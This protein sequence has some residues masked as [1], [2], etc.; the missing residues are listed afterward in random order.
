MSYYFILLICSHLVAIKI[1]LHTTKTTT[2]ET[3]TNH[4][5]EVKI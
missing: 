4:L 5:R 3:I 2:N 1:K